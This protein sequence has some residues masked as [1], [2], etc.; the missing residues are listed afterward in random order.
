MRLLTTTLALLLIAATPAGANALRERLYDATGGVMV[1][2]HRGCHAAAPAHGF[3]TSAPE[4][5]LEA[6]RRCIDIGVDMVEADVRRTQDG[7]L[8]ITARTHRTQARNRADALARLNDLV[9]RAASPPKKR[10]RTG[11]TPSQKRKRLD[12]KKQ[13]AHKKSLR[14]KPDI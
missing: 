8:V 12:A 10:K 3:A 4:N 9:A 1:V 13:H 6:L 5:S 7:V 2:A 14:G 11:V